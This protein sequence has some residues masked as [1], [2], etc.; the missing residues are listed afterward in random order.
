MVL[1]DDVAALPTDL[2][3]VPIVV[4]PKDSMPVDYIRNN[5]MENFKLIPEWNWV[6]KCAVTSRE[7]IL[8]SGGEID[9]AEIKELRRKSRDAVV[10]CVKHAYPRLLAEGIVPDYCVILD[11]R[12]VTGT[13]THGVVRKDLFSKVNKKTTF[14]VASMTDPS[15]TELL[16]HK[17]LKVKAWHAYTDAIMEEPG[18]TL[19]VAKGLPIAKDVTLVTGG[20]ASAMRAIG[21]FHSFGS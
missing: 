3:K 18:K 6:Q 10:V 13:S 15:V 8:V 11:P 16:L 20:T 9:F 7:I 4:H 21:M 5:V 12:P 19:E 17:K 1:K 14:L 2:I